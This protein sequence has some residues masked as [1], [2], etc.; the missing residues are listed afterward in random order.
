MQNKIPFQYLK[1]K[2]ICRWK[3]KGRGIFAYKG[4]IRTF[5]KVLAVLSL[6]LRHALI[7]TMTYFLVKI[8]P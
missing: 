7:M 8:P 4:T 6:G 2:K 5:L 1:F 3:E